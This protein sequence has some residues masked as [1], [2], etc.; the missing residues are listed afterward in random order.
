MK[1]I[2]WNELSGNERKSLFQTPASQ[3]NKAT[4][5]IVKA[6][7][8]DVRSSG[9]AALRRCTLKFDKY[10]PLPIFLDIRQIEAAEERIDA[11]LR[12]AMEAAYANIK[13]FHS[14]QGYQPFS[15]ETLPG[16]TCTR[17][18]VP[19]EK[20]GVYVPAGTAPLFSAALMLGV[21]SQ[22]AGNPVRILCTPG[23]KSGEV[24]PAT[25]FA[26][27]LCGMTQVAR[28]GG[29]QAIAALAFGTESVPAVDKIFGPGNM[30]V[31]QAKILAASMPGGPA[32]DMPAGPSEVLVIVDGTTPDAYAAADL[33][34]QAEHD[35]MAQV[36]LVAE[37]ET[38]INAILAYVERQL[39][40]LPRKEIARSSIE[41]S[42]AIVVSSKDQAIEVS[43]LYAPE[44]LILCFDDCDKYLDR[45]TNA[46]SVFCGTLTPESF[47]DYASG[48]NHILPTGIAP[49][50]YSGLT[51]EAFQKTITVQRATREVF[52]ALSDTV[53]TMARAEQLEAHARAVTLRKESS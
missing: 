26:A 24:H 17:K 9:D 39:E 14:R 44:H 50:A 28:I 7:M 35:M 31:T 12:Q 19:I 8:E 4:E 30:Y 20:V 47:G 43:N 51:A 18:V 5:D 2:Y 25:L 36:V 38:K 42:L 40:T 34:A 46:G 13:A 6:I 45:I 41:N 52:Q 23:N 37:S 15:I 32:I 29:A 48:T 3:L 21:P 27:K 10:D 49:R 1:K 33:L 53:I 22:I 11:S 16:L